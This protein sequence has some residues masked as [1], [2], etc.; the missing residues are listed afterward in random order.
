MNVHFLPKRIMGAWIEY[1]DPLNRQDALFSLGAW[2]LSSKLDLSSLSE[3]GEQVPT[4]QAAGIIHLS[5]NEEEADRTDKEDS[6]AFDQFGPTML[7]GLVEQSDV[8]VTLDYNVN[9]KCWVVRTGLKT[10][11]ARPQRNA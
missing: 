5:K 4:A 3:P 2:A 8:K 9:S 10:S 7:A 6:G 1:S 11:L